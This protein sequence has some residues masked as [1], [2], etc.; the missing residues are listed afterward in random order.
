MTD[1]LMTW[2]ELRT[3]LDTLEEGLY[4]PCLPLTARE[5]AMLRAGPTGH[6]AR[7]VMGLL[8]GRL[9]RAWTAQGWVT[10]PR[11]RG[12]PSSS[13]PG[14]PTPRLRLP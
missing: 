6:L 2:E 3:A 14:T 4:P 12:R 13:S 10:R 1:R 5:E 9:E 11:D 8:E 7:E